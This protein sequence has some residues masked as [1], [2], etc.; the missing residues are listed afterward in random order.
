MTR[1]E[2]DDL[3]S[4][5]GQKRAGTDE[6]SACPTL[7][8]GCKGCLDVARAENIGKDQPE[9]E[10]LCRG[11]HISSL[12]LGFS[13]DRVREHGDHGRLGYKLT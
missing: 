6:Q 7:D 12:C 2:P 5:G 1:G 4:M 13:A 3:F 11:L 10:F 9:P 8:E